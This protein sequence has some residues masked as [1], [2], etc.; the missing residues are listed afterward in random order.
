VWKD[1]GQLN[2]FFNPEPMKTVS[3]KMSASLLFLGSGV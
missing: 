3:A 2:Y 1:E